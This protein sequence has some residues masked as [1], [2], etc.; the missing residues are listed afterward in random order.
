MGDVDDIAGEDLSVADSLLSYSDHVNGESSNGPVRSVSSPPVMRHFS[1]RR[2]SK[3][4]WDFVHLPHTSQQS[5]S[6]ETRSGP[7]DSAG[8]EERGYSLSGGPTFAD[9]HSLTILTC[10]LGI[11]T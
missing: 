3:H 11:A 9:R 6:C 10:G 7:S 1:G 2:E 4:F 5:R 8:R